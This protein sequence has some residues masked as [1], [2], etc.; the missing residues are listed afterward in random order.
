MREAAV[1]AIVHRARALV[2][3]AARP[4]RAWLGAWPAPGD[5][6]LEA[7]LDGPLGPDGYAPRVTRAEPREVEV[8]VVLDMSLS[9]TGEAIALVAL[10]TAV[11]RLRLEHVAVV[12]FGSDAHTLVRVGEPASVREVVRRVLEVQTQGYTHIAAGL[13]AGADELARSRRR[14]RVGLLFTDGNGNMGGDPVPVSAR[15]PRLHV[16]QLGAYNPAGARNCAGMARAGRGRVIRSFT[17]Q[18]LPIVVRRTVSELFR[19]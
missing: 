11:L 13:R 15:F 5:L 14:E 19:S 2:R 4:T 6:D 9:M 12:A 7:T 16:V 1:T 17:Y 3:H 8:V 10:A 18:D